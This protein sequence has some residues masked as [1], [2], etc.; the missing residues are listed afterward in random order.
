MRMCTSTG[1][2]YVQGSSGFSAA[3]AC[4]HDQ[5]TL[6][7]ALRRSARVQA[8]TVC[9]ALWAAGLA[10][11]SSATYSCVLTTPFTSLTTALASSSLVFRLPLPSYPLLLGPPSQ[12]GMLA[13]TLRDRA[14]ALL[15]E[16]ARW[17]PRPSITLDMVL[18]AALSVRLG[19]MCM[20][21]R[22][23]LIV[24]ATY[25]QIMQP[26]L[27]H[28]SHC[29]TCVASGL[30][31]GGI[32]GQEHAQRH[33]PSLQPRGERHWLLHLLQAWLR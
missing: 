19:D 3:Y 20:A 27:H 14:V 32:A 5:S 30:V 25:S 33:H 9:L 11:L 15:R 23:P 10:R 1:L 12:A 22:G 13:V 29:G 31:R 26:H 28:P 21:R 7:N 2:G 17:T 18:C 16:Q 24:T 6:L 8:H 4:Q